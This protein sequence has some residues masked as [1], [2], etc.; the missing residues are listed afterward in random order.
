M[1]PHNKKNCTTRRRFLEYSFFTGALGALALTDTGHA[2][3]VD[4]ALNKET[5]STKAPLRLGLM[6]Y[7]L[8]KDWNLDTVIRNCQQAKFEHA[9]LR[10]THAHGVEVSLS[11]AQRHE[12]RKKFEDAGIRLSLASAFAY[13]WPDQTKL[14]EHIEGTKEYTLLAQDIGALGI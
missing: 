4:A 13:H 3:S 12:V 9:E 11:K 5:A 7:N 1:N 8:A 2:I 6:T 10:T 14:R